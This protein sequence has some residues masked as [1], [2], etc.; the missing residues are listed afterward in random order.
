MPK[1]RSLIFGTIAGACALA[2]LF[3]TYFGVQVVYFALTYEGEGSLGH[4][5]MY[6][7]A[8]L[9]PLLALLFGG[10]TYLA[11]RSARRP[12]DHPLEE[13]PADA[14]PEPPPSTPPLPSPRRLGS[15]R[16]FDILRALV[17]LAGGLLMLQALLGLFAT[18]ADRAW[19][20]AFWVILNG[21]LGW[22]LLNAGLSGSLTGRTPA[23]RIRGG[24]PRRIR[25]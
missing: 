20:P 6:I 15:L 24:R 12:P 2:T 21:L 13:P 9:Y 1:P 19:G 17:A 7:G 11:W 14:E 4:V 18:V 10:C 25:R 23:N 16:P 3:F 5:G 8:V 22:W